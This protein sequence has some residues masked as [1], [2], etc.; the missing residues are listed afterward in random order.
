MFGMQEAPATK[1]VTIRMTFPF[2]IVTTDSSPS[3]KSITKMQTSFKKI[4]LN[5]RL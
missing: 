2:L 3:Q 4:I 5:H 1:T